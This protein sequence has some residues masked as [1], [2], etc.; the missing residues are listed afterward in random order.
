MKK[1][2]YVPVC[3]THGVLVLCAS[4]TTTGAK[5]AAKNVTNYACYFH[6]CRGIKVVKYAPVQTT[7]PVRRKS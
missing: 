1:V 3:P 6:S 4:E 5:D 7:I 2:I